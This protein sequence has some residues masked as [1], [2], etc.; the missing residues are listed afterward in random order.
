[1]GRKA[2]ELPTPPEVKGLVQEFK[3]RL[4]DTAS[5]PDE[6]SAFDAETVRIIMEELNDTDRA[7]LLT[8]YGICDGS[9]YQTSKIFNT[10]NTVIIYRIKKIMK[11]ITERN[12]IPRTTYNLPRQCDID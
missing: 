3:R 4:I 1:M 8:C 9:T 12:D 6:T 5:R 2:K 11:Y 10:S 7:I